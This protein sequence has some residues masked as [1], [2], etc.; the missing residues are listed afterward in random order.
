MRIIAI[1][2]DDVI[3]SC[4]E[5]FLKYHNKRYNTDLS[6]AKTSYRGEYWGYFPKLLNLELGISEEEGE[7]RF[8]EFLADEAHTKHQPISDDAK[9]A[10]RELKKSY[11]LEVITARDV[12]MRDST[13]KWLN[14]HLPCTFHGVHFASDGHKARAK[15]EICREIG[16]EFL[17]DDS[18]EHCNTAAR[19]GIEVILFGEYGWNVGQE[20]L[21]TVTRLTSWPE[22]AR[23][24]NEKA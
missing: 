21:P 16:A 24:F 2:I 15:A 14:D 17:V 8:K 1:D 20:T 7:R 18:I 19:E 13:V 23:Y 22:I 12:S 5:T 4:G 10:I 3:S 11:R 6:L 9:R